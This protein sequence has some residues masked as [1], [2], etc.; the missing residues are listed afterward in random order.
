MKLLTGTILALLNV[1][2]ATHTKGCSP[3]PKVTPKA[4]Y[5]FSINL[6]LGPT[7]DVGVDIYDARQSYLIVTG[8]S[9]CAKW[10]GG[11]TGTIVVS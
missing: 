6:V 9:F 8:G 11:T 4:Q 2:L 5:D 7:L 1:A 3:S 10:N